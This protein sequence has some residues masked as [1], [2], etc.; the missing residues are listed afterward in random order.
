MPCAIHVPSTFACSHGSPLHGT[1]LNGRAAM[2]TASP[3]LHETAIVSL[4]P[5]AALADQGRPCREAAELRLIAAR[6]VRS[7]TKVARCRLPH[8]RTNYLP[9]P[10]GADLP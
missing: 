7:A 1:N 10:I 8:R 3:S 6:A 4:P 5:P 9:L 2:T